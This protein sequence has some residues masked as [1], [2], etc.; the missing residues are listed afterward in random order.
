MKNT[1]S[2]EEYI[3]KLID[4]N[5]LKSK[6]LRNWSY[7]AYVFSVL[8][9]VVLF[10]LF[11]ESISKPP[12]IMNSIFF[13]VFCLLLISFSVVFIRS[14]LSLGNAY[15]LRSGQLEDIKLVLML[16]KI[17]NIPIENSLKIVLSFQR[18]VMKEMVKSSLP[19]N[20]IQKSLDKLSDKIGF[21]V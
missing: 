17:Q 18:D 20:F 15:S 3:Q 6:K 14:L 4:E 10:Y 21:N 12:E 19:D 5:N 8:M 1:S 11:Q 16:N 7:I 2:I 13:I 9:V